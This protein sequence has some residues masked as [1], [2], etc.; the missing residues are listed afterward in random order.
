MENADFDFSDRDTNP[1]KFLISASV[2]NVLAGCR[3]RGD[4]QRSHSSRL[5]IDGEPAEHYALTRGYPGPRLFGSRVGLAHDS[6]N[7][8]QAQNS[9]MAITPSAGMPLAWLADHAPNPII[10][11]PNVEH[12]QTTGARYAIDVISSRH[13]QQFQ[14]TSTESE[15]AS[16]STRTTRTAVGASC[17]L[18]STWVSPPREIALQLLR[19]LAEHPWFP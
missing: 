7:L 16:Y 15:N 5:Y 13:P 4:A 8:R 14:K 12:A 17:V 3:I 19:I 2:A 10:C 18:C 9:L 1:H 11:L 6:V